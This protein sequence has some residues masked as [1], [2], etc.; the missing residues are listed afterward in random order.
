MI[1]TTLKQGIILLFIINYYGMDKSNQQFSQFQ[2]KKV[3]F[4]LNSEDLGFELKENPSRFKVLEDKA[5]KSEIIH[6][7]ISNEQ[8]F[9]INIE[10]LN[11]YFDTENESTNQKN[12]NPKMILVS[13]NI[14]VLLKENEQFLCYEIV[15]NS[16]DAKELTK[17]LRDKSPKILIWNS[18]YPH[19]LE[20]LVGK[21]YAENTQREN[22]Y[23]SGENKVINTKYVKAI[24]PSNSSKYNSSESKF[25]TAQ[26]STNDGVKSFTDHHQAK[27]HYFHDH[28]DDEKNYKHDEKN[29][30]SENQNYKDKSSSYQDYSKNR[31]QNDEKNEY[32]GL[33]S[34]EKDPLRNKDLGYKSI[35]KNHRYENRDRYK[36]DEKN[37]YSYQSWSYKKDQC[38]STSYQKDKHSSHS[39]NHHEEHFSR[40]ERHDSSESKYA[41]CRYGH[42]DHNHRQYPSSHQNS[43]NHHSNPE[44]PHTRHQYNEKNSHKSRS[45]SYNNDRNYFNKNYK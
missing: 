33:S 28:R 20:N 7:G 19:L 3:R 31:N 41:Q 39:L 11:R 29:E 23:I 40:N 42:Q 27:H 12:E 32:R 45:R 6:N 25:D 37:K 24:L 8:E 15:G 9:I 18:K 35:N 38:P 4:A 1:K 36:Y 21:Y 2:K 10:N 26:Y 22:P 44:D 13:E 16:D 14:Q 5:P 43:R 30:Y 34:D 17:R